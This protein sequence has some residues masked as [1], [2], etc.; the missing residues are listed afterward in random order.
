MV[1]KNLASI[2]FAGALTA[3]PLAL[4]EESMS[5]CE[6]LRVHNIYHTSSC[7]IDNKPVILKDTDYSKLT[8]SEELKI[9]VSPNSIKNSNGTGLKLPSFV[10]I[11]NVG[12]RV[13]A[14]YMPS[15][16]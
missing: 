1:N 10:F 14:T 2:I 12:N 5:Y 8:P 15:K 4:G 16:K 7:F 6:M 3:S 13:Y 11:N 9:R